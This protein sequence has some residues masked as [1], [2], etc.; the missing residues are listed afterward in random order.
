MEQIH[1]ETLDVRPVQILI[2]HD[3]DTTITESLDV[4]VLT[5]LLETEDL[6][7]RR[8]F[9]IFVELLLTDVLDVKQLASERKDTPLLPTNNLE[10]RDGT[11]GS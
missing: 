6:L 9:L 2:C 1:E 7:D 3:H 8:Q 11:R 10:S 5:S 4:L